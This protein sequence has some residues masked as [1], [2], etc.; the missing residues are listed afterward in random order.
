MVVEHFKEGAAGGVY[1]RFASQG[2][3]MPPGLNHVE[4]W[5][6]ADVKACFQLVET[7]DVELLVS[8][9][10]QWD[11]LIEFE[12]ILVISSAEARDKALA[13]PPGV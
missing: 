12:I 13:D 9:T 6:S 5:V 1:R 8:W 10:R 7:D 3:M 2:R 4:S 11:D